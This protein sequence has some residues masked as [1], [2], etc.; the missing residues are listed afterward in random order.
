MVAVFPQFGQTFQGVKAPGFATARHVNFNFLAT[1]DWWPPAVAKVVPAAATK[2][3]RPAERLYSHKIRILKK[4]MTRTG[5]R[6]LTAS[7]NSSRLV[8][9]ASMSDVEQCKW[10][11]N[12][13]A[14]NFPQSMSNKQD[15]FFPSPR[16][17][18]GGSNEIRATNEPDE[19]SFRSKGRIKRI[20]NGDELTK[21]EKYLK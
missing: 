4:A 21:S 16:K 1:I 8:D 14:E 12:R 20:T 9:F 7:R 18:N 13:A 19:K 17:I 2:E 11:A 10:A 15:D 3:R 6:R 5:T